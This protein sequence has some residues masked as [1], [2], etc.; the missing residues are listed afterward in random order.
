M[1]YYVVSGAFLY[2]LLSL[3]SVGLYVRFFRD[4]ELA[5][6]A[7]R[8]FYLFPFTFARICVRYPLRLLTMTSRWPSRS[9][10]YLFEK[11]SGQKTYR[12]KRINYYRR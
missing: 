2:L 5:R 9:A 1:I 10:R 3:I 12:R 7:R 11:I 8:N 6:F 4:T